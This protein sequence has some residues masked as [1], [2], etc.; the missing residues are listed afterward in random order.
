MALIPWFATQSIWGVFTNSCPYIPKCEASSANAN[1][2]FGRFIILKTP[3]TS[4]SNHWFQD[5]VLLT[6]GTG[7]SSCQRN[8]PISGI[9]KKHLIRLAKII[10]L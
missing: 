3:L 8:Q 1:R 5:Y 4:E 7:K 2:I 9:R 6:H 10:Q